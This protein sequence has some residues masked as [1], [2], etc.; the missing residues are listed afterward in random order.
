[1]E[2]IFLPILRLDNIE[3]IKENIYKT[4]HFIKVQPSDKIQY[5]IY[6][7]TTGVNSTFKGFEI[8]ILRLDDAKN[9][10]T[11]VIIQFRKKRSII[12]FFS[13]PN[14]QIVN[15]LKKLCDREIHEAC[16]KKFDPGSIVKEHVNEQFLYHLGTL[17][18]QWKEQ[19]KLS[20]L[21]I[22]T[23]EDLNSYLVEFSFTPLCYGRKS[24]KTILKDDWLELFSIYT[25]S[26]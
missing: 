19:N 10:Y 25:P 17:N 13:N 23:K 7:E 14:K 22:Y 1:M 11:G 12:D 20:P 6:S 9:D 4:L 2:K 21:I 8:E 18:P 3:I 5:R 24:G 26:W 16:F 15:H